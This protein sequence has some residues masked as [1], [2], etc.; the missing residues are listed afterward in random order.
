MRESVKYCSSA[1]G[2]HHHSHS[3][4]DNRELILSFKSI[5]INTYEVLVLKFDGSIVFR[6]ESFHLWEQWIKGIFISSHQF[7]SISQAGIYAQSLARKKSIVSYKDPANNKIER[8]L[9]SL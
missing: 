3:V 5:Y 8:R 9:H 7:L 2:E 6:H 4:W 1:K